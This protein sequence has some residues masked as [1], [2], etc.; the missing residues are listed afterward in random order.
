MKSLIIMIT[1]LLLFSACSNEA[2]IEVRNLRVNHHRVIGILLTPQL[3]LQTQEVNKIGSNEWQNQYTQIENF[4]YEP[5]NIY[6]IIVEVIPRDEVLADQSS[7]R[8]ILK[9]IVSTESIPPEVSFQIT[10]KQYSESYV[11]SDDNSNF[12]ILKQIDIECNTLCDQ[13]NNALQSQ[14]KVIGIFTRLESDKLKLIAIE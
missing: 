5:G 7:V 2:D 6:D 14:D 9:E 3:I 13:L 12:S 4:N 10:L 1:S 11:F 8:Y